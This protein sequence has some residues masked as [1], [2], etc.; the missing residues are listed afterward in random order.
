MY[1]ITKQNVLAY[2]LYLSLY[3][4]VMIRP[5]YAQRPAVIPQPVALTQ[6]SEVFVLNTDTRLYR[7]INIAESN[8]VFFNQYVRSIAGI[9]LKASTQRTG[10]NLVTLT[11][12]SVAVKQKEG[13]HLAIGNKGIQLTGNNEAGVFYGLQTLI[14]LMQPVVGKRI[15]IPGGNITDYPR[16]AYRGMHLDVSR[17][18]FPVSA[19]K[20]WIDILALYKINTFHWHLTDDQGWRIEI[21][22][23]PALQNI[24]AYRNETL[25]GHKKE[26]PHQFDGQRYGGYYTQ[27]EAKA[28]VRYAAERHITVIPEIE[29]PGHALA[30]LAAYPQLGC[31]GGPYQTATYWG[32][33]ND[34]YCAGNE[35]TFTFLEDV[36]SEVINIFPSQYIHI[37]GDECPKDKWK[38]CPKCQ[39][40]IKTE[41]L[42]NEHE[43]QSYF[44]KR[45]SNYLATQGRKIIG[46]DEILEGGLTP[47]ATVMSWTGEQGGIESARQ[48][49]QAIMTPEKQVY[50]DYYQSLYATDSLAAGGY[51]PLSK[52]YS[53]EPVPAS[54]TPAEASY[55]LGVQ[56][57][58]W[59]EYITNTRKAEYMMFPRMLALAEIAWS[60]KA[61]RNLPGFL[62]RTRV[63]LK[64][65]K[66][67]GINAADNFDQITD[68]VTTS[69]D[70]TLF[71][72]LK[73]S[74]PNAQLRY[75][76][77]GSLPDAFSL[78]YTSALPVKKT[79]TVKAA[80]FIGKT[81]YQDIYTKQLV[82]SKATG[83]KVSL[84]NQPAGNYNPGSTDRMVNGLTGNSRYNNGEWFGFSGTNMVATIDL[85]KPQSI[86]SIATHVLNYHWQKMWPPVEMVFS[87]SADGVNYQDVYRQTNFPLNGINTVGAKI[88]AVTARY[89]RVNAVNQG[90][91]PAGE[92]GTGAAAWL[93]VDEFIIN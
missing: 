48:H 53:Y 13:Y 9:T 86:S 92:Y 39:Q 90:T 72:T 64:L 79:C 74:L 47:G 4:G 37:G 82:V 84:Q 63:N 58:L 29:M 22:K 73:S 75:T 50:L 24:S 81:R 34:V 55:I 76:T 7:S 66:K 68:T 17:H 89:V 16:F 6:N 93:L 36:L 31:T 30:A 56:A 15:N 41:H 8:L 32:V 69:S 2:I 35:A 49:H 52:L 78:K 19:I 57:N 12:D 65:L 62:T 67:Q 44:I 23:Y 18:L 26:L 5:C 59:T 61:T 91:I 60:P 46:W 42:K 43:L 14:Q 87:I 40:R 70:G 77:D 20:K 21:K 11:I 88:P 83:K 1:C 28:I 45:I 10:S 51:T 38:V 54:L 3:L 85:G 33:F 27:A 80:L 71:L 25:I